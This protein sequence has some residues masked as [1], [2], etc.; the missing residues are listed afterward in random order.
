[1]ENTSLLTGNYIFPV[2]AGNHTLQIVLNGQAQPGIPVTIFPRP[3]FTNNVKTAANAKSTAETGAQSSTADKAII[4]PQTIADINRTK[5]DFPG[6]PWLVGGVSGFLVVVLA[7]AALFAVHL[8]RKSKQQTGGEPTAGLHQGAAGQVA[9]SSHNRGSEQDE[10]AKAFPESTENS[11]EITGPQAFLWAVQ[12]TGGPGLEQAPEKTGGFRLNPSFGGRR[13]R[14]KG[15]V[16][17]P[18]LLSRAVQKM[19]ERKSGLSEGEKEKETGGTAGKG[20]AP[21]LPSDDMEP[22]PLTKETQGLSAEVAEKEAGNK[23]DSVCG[24]AGVRNGATLRA[25]REDESPNA[26]GKTDGV[27]N[28]EKASEEK[29]HSFPT[30]PGQKIGL[31]SPQGAQSSALWSPLTFSAVPSL[32]TDQPQSRKRRSPKAEPPK[33]RTPRNRKMS[34]FAPKKVNAPA[35]KGKVNDREVWSPVRFVSPPVAKPGKIRRTE[36]RE[37]RRGDENAVRETKARKALVFRPTPLDIPGATGPLRQSALWSPVKTFGQ[38]QPVDMLN[39]VDAKQGGGV[40]VASGKENVARGR[41]N[42]PTR[43]KSNGESSKPAPAKR[44]SSQGEKDE[45]EEETATP[46]REEPSLWSPTFNY[47]MEAEAT[48]Q[49]AKASS[50]QVLSDG[51]GSPHAK[52]EVTN[53]GR[54]LP[55]RATLS[56]TSGAEIA[57]LLQELERRTSGQTPGGQHT[58]SPYTAYEKLMAD[59]RRKGRNESRARRSFDSIEM[60]EE[61]A[62]RAGEL[63]SL[64]GDSVSYDVSSADAGITLSAFV[65]V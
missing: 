20:G 2:Q 29:Q 49:K 35:Q 21:G 37:P 44:V 45:A 17:S 33:P 16:G 30:I 58:L 8:R 25:E 32:F 42:Q 19:R 43:F 1:M 51:E 41:T 65:E 59:D 18:M 50:G 6:W 15:A 56:S 14:A 31:A 39:V 36:G 26:K 54:R 3:S 52:K 23:G 46:L 34:I 38:A 55:G 57:A 47:L 22:P 24:E 48:P 10:S 9:V 4:K 60:V 62:G 61:T 64:K 53:V 40:L 27:S 5:N 63:D 13:P 7:G 11:G 12:E 28:I